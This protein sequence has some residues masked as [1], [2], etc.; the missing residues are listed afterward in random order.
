[1]SLS[2]E[3]EPRRS[4]GVVSLALPGPTASDYAAAYPYQ[5]PQAIGPVPDVQAQGAATLVCTRLA[6]MPAIFAGD[7]KYRSAKRTFGLIMSQTDADAKGGTNQIPGLVKSRCGVTVKTYLFADSTSTENSDAQRIAT[8]MKADGITTALLMGNLQ[9]SPTMTSAAV[10]SS[11]LPEWFDFDVNRNATARQMNSKAVADMVFVYPWHP[12]SFA[13]DKGECYRIY[14][15]ADPTGE[16]ES[17]DTAGGIFDNACANMLQMFGA[18]Q[19]AGPDLTP[20]TFGAGWFRQPASNGAGD[21][22]GWAH[23]TQFFSPESTFTLQYWKPGVSNPY[24]SGKG[25]YVA[26]DEPEDI[27]YLSSKMGSGQL[28]C[29]GR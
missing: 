17:D 11:Y 4:S 10:Q 3:D 12:Q 15:M 21:F 26:C 19:A 7:S 8:Q 29:L 13:P 20:A 27:G 14:K 22:G 18:L 9:F 6:N 28:K 25:M 23:T 16:P 24:D 5:F 2:T 1:L